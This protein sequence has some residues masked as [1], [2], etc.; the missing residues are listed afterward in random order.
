MSHFQYSL[1]DSRSLVYLVSKL[2]VDLARY[3][4]TVAVAAQVGQLNRIFCA[5]A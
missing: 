4:E 5:A 3:I 2:Q 1:K